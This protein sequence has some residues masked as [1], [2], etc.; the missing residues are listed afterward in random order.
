MRLLKEIVGWASIGLLAAM[1]ARELWSPWW[2]WWVW[3]AVRVFGV[4]YI[5]A[6]IARRVHNRRLRTT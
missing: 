4:G 2:L 5:V 3:D 6:W 1:V